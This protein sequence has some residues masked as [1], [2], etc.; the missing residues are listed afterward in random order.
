[1]QSREP[2]GGGGRGAGEEG[3]ERE[4]G[5]GKAGIGG[6]GLWVEGSGKRRGC[7]GA[8][9]EF[10]VGQGPHA[11]YEYGGGIYGSERGRSAGRVQR[12]VLAVR[13]SLGC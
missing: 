11:Q 10:L 3:G 13:L 5:W 4:E 2:R 7:G 8:G 9:K 6:W 12:G 1:M